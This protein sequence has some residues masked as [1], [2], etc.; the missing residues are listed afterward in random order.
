MHEV[1]IR[2]KSL[3]EAR[4]TAAFQLGVKEDQIEIEVVEDPHSRPDGS[5]ESYHVR[6]RIRADAFSPHSP[7]ETPEPKPSSPEGGEHETLDLSKFSLAAGDSEG[8]LPEEEAAVEEQPEAEGYY[9]EGGESERPEEDAV[10][11]GEQ[12]PLA[13]PAEEEEELG[14]PKHEV[15]ENA[16]AFLEGLL[17][18][19]GLDS[20]V[21][22]KHV[23]AEEV[24]VE[25]EGGDLAFLIG[26]YG[27]CLDALQLLTAA[28]ANRG[29][30]EGARVVV[31]A[32]GYRQRR[33]ESLERLAH[34]TAAKVRRT[35]RPIELR[36]LRPHE[37]R[38]VH[39][40]LRDDPDVET[41]S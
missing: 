31:D 4:K 34:S 28:A 7:E 22:I 39:L 9:D 11:G 30:G 3:E 33:R 8:S 1:E 26:R 2:A 38:V 23:G 24:E 41:Y 5:I 6:A 25:L 10:T 17:Q 12:E 36:D 14:E 18:V 27:S 40:A 32:E 20:Q 35:G 19:L 13:E 15:A 21:V 29:V 16:R 37:R